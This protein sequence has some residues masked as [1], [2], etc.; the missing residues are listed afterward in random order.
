MVERTSYTHGTPSWTDLSTSDPQKAM[1]FYGPLF[2]WEFDELPTDQGGPYIMATK[3]GKTV[4]ALMQ[5]QEDQAAMGIPSMWNTYVSVDDVG[6]TISKVEGAGG[7][8]MM[9]PMDVMDAGKM[10]V[11]VD[12]TGAV[13]CLW[14][15]LGTIGAQLVNEHGTLCWNEVITND[16]PAATAFYTELFGWGTQTMDMGEQGTYTVFTLGEDGIGGSP[17]MPQPGVPPHWSTVF[18]VD[19]CAAAISTAVKQDGTVIVEPFTTPIGTMA[20]VA[21][22]TGAMFQ[23]IELSEAAE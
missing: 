8:V 20:V 2:G 16:V 12:P 3:D 13:L 5:Q 11:I 17:G 1:S 9:P 18:A 7:T 21:D 10:A 23:L 14:Q 22:P 15:P 19:D 4:A 6:D